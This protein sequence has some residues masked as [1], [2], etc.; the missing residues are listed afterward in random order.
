MET[1]SY[2]DFALGISQRISGKRIPLRGTIEVTRRCP[3]ACGHCYNNLPMED[4]QARRSELSYEEHCRI[5]DEI[6]DSGCFWLLYTGGEIFARQDFIDIYKH[7]KQK[8]LLITLF[9][10]A[11]LINEKIADSLAEYPPHYIEI[12]LYGHTKQ[13]YEKITGRPGSFERC[14]R[15]IQLLMERGLPVKLK[16]VTMTLNKHEI[17]EMKRF[18]EEDLG[19]EFRFDAMINPRLDGSQRPLD[20]RLAPEEVVNLDLED[21][22]RLAEWNRFCERHTGPGIESKQSH[23]LYQCGGGVGSFAIDPAGNLSLCGMSASK[24][25]DLLQGSFRDGWEDFISGVRQ[26][27]ISRKTKCFAC[28]IK[29]MCGMCPATGELEKGD[30]EEPVDFLCRVAHLRAHALGLT[31]PPHGDCEY[32]KNPLS[33][34]LP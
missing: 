3:L 2:E 29:A 31:V 30:P 26:K 18:V 27:K 20:L 23:D 22:E 5:L 6:V 4:Q 24:T 28:E 34:P 19:L 8:G 33:E 10:N 15:G 7:A 25:Y 21:P 12:T 11:V 16:T 32:C 9:T 14:M 1:V 13:T 17:W